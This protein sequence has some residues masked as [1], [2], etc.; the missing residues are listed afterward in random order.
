MA[1]FE[2]WGAEAPGRAPGGNG[3]GGA[4]AE[5]SADDFDLDVTGDWGLGGSER[6]V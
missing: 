5:G 2:S 4:L 3:S 1:G 6:Q